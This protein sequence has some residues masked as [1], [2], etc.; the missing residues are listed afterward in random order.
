MIW[1][2]W[3]WH[4]GL[5]VGDGYVI[6]RS[7]RCGGVARRPLTAFSDGR[8]I[9]NLGHSGARQRHEVVQTAYELIGSP[10]AL[11][12]RNC[13]SFVKECQGRMSVSLQTVAGLAALS[14][15]C[16]GLAKR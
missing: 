16:I 13:E 7:A 10:W 15:L 11:L 2:G 9:T 6:D 8:T 14:A 4:F 3:F 1:C 12:D 5:Y